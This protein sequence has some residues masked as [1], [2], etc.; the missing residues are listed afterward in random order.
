MNRQD[1]KNA[2]SQR[3]RQEKKIKICVYKLFRIAICLFMLLF[4]AIING[5]PLTFDDTA[6]YIGSGFDSYV[7]QDRP[8]FYGFFIRQTSL[9]I[10]LWLTVVAQSL[11]LLFC[12]RILN[13]YFFRKNSSIWLIFALSFLSGVSWVTSCVMPDIFIPIGILSV[14]EILFFKSLLN[15]YEKVILFCIFCLSIMV[16]LSS[17]PILLLFLI[18]ILAIAQIANINI[19]RIKRDILYLLTTIILLSFIIIPGINKTQNAGFSLSKGGPVFFA[20]RLSEARVLK[21]L[22]EFECPKLR[23]KACDYIN[24]YSSNLNKFLWDSSSP[25]NKF[26]NSDFEKAAK[27]FSPINKKF[28]SHPKL[29]FQFAMSSLNNTFKQLITFDIYDFLKPPDK[30][31]KNQISIHLPNDKSLLK[32]TFDNFKTKLPIWTGDDQPVNVP[33]FVYYLNNF[34]AFVFYISFLFIV[35]F[36]TIDLI[37]KTPLLYAHYLILL[38]ILSVIINALVVGTLSSYFHRYQA[39]V[40]WLVP[41]CLIIY[42]HQNKVLSQLTGRKGE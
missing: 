5:Y 6:T 4:P 35:I 34:Y 26:W 7:P 18:T 23:T 17:I 37:K 21:P 33:I 13:K 32:D 19:L 38:L 31:V 2:F 30:Y 28:F 27:D 20:A 25:F 39:R 15:K 24:D 36:T 22:M 11:L 14:L 8:I 16:H 10:S 3:L 29:V 42:L 9:G 41:L 40:I 12:L 1:A